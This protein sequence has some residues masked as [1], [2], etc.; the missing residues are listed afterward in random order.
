MLT[1]SG[2]EM[3]REQNDGWTTVLPAADAAPV[4]GTA[5]ATSADLPAVSKTT[6]QLSS[7][8]Q[9]SYFCTLS[10]FMISSA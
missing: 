1:K 3:L 7:M 6:T 9:Y 5:A 2:R 8:M 4:P 10:A